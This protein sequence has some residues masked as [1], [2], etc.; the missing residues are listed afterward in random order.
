ML[1]HLIYLAPC[2][3]IAVYPNLRHGLQKKQIIFLLWPLQTSFYVISQSLLS[4]NQYKLRITQPYLE[5]VKNPTVFFWLSDI[6]LMSGQ[7]DKLS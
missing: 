3:F 5:N 4:L 6:S 1:F 7:K 2:S